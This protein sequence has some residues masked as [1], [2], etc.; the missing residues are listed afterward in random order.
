MLHLLV[1]SL[2]LLLNRRKERKEAKEGQFKMEMSQ[3]CFKVDRYIPPFQRI[4]MGRRI[5]K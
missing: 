3:R 4:R 5:K 2:D 1:L